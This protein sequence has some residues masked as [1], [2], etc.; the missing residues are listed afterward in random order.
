[1]RF[2]QSH[3]ALWIFLLPHC[4]LCFLPSV[5]PSYLVTLCLTTQCLFH[6]PHRAPS[7]NPFTFHQ[8]Y[9][10]HARELNNPGSSHSAASHFPPKLDH[11]HPSW[12]TLSAPIGFCTDEIA[13]VLGD[14]NHTG[15]W[16]LTAS[17][18]Y[19][20]LK[21][22]VQISQIFRG[23]KDERLIFKKIFYYMPLKILNSLI[24]SSY[25]SPTFPLFFWTLSD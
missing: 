9:L 1:M 20:T 5:R 19:C 8:A 15:T 12:L 16:Y 25:V 21:L 11:S 22:F 7:S 17:T 13:H 6:E 14:I 23:N 10:L 2:F 18:L 4:L 24:P 3:N